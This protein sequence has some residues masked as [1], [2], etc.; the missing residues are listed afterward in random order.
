MSGCSRSPIKTE[1]IYIEVPATLTQATLVPA[2]SGE[3][4]GDAVEYIPECVAAIRSCNADKAA[5]KAVNERGP[6][7]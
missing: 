1:Y 5:I 6:S 2:Y 3:T 4:F 7:E